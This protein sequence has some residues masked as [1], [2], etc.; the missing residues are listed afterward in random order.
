[1]KLRFILLFYILFP[2][3]MLGQI[4]LSGKVIDK[5]NE[6]VAFANVI[7]TE[8]GTDKVKG[9][10]TDKTGSFELKLSSALYEVEIS[11]VGYTSW[12]ETINLEN[13]DIHLGVIKLAESAT[14]LNEIVIQ[15]KRPVIENKIDRLVFNVGNSTIASGGTAIDII[16]VTPGVIAN[17]N[18]ISMIGRSGV[19]V[20]ING[21]LIQL[22]GEEL[23]SYLNT[24]SSNN[25]KSVEVITS[26]P[27]KYDAE[28]NAGLINIVLRK[29]KRNSWYNYA[30]SNYT[31][32]TYSG[33]ALGNTFLFNKNKFSLYASIDG[34]LG[35]KAQY[36]ESTI[37]Y[38]EGIWQGKTD[39]KKRLDNLSGRFTLGYNI[40]PKSSVGITYQGSI[41]DKDVHDRDKTKIFNSQ[42]IRV[43]EVISKGMNDR[44]GENHDLN[45]SYE[46]Q[47]DTLGKK[48]EAGLDYFQYK[49]D[50]SRVFTSE[51]IDYNPQNYGVISSNTQE[52]TNYNF[53][54]DILHPIGKT[55][56]SYGGKM[57]FTN[58]V[59]QLASE[60][61]LGRSDDLILQN[62]HF[63]YDENIQAIYADATS[64]INEK[65]TLKLGLRLE[66]TQTKGNSLTTSS[67]FSRDYLNL[68]PTIYFNHNPNKENSYN[69]SYSRRIR[70]PQ[71]SDLNPFR[72]YINAISYTEGNPFLQPQTSH[73]FE[74][75][76]SYKN[77]IISRIFSS[78]S[79]NGYGQIPS[80]DRENNQQIYIRKNFYNSTV[81][82]ASQIYLKDIFSWWKTITQATFYHFSSSYINN[83]SLSTDLNKG[84]NF[85]FYSNH[86][87]TLS[88]L[89]SAEFTFN[90]GAP[91]TMLL[92]KTSSSVSVDLGFR[93]KLFDEKLHLNFSAVD[94]L[95]TSART[96][97]AMTNGVPQEYYNYND[98]RY[99]RLGL[100]YK[101][102]NSKIKARTTKSGNR[103]EQNRAG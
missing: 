1:M 10:T 22:S 98:N 42:N 85:Q 25:I 81:I 53:N 57:T 19:G 18:A 28:G 40:T 34:T 102:G 67:E 52:V 23:L 44:E 43:G 78:I 88:K 62:D 66:A 55:M 31:Q 2:V 90:Y 13:K 100:E 95:K 7:V 71:F 59:N 77:S 84:F 9:K 47:L 61:L 12:N 83:I 6:P 32:R 50:Q 36:I 86:N 79:R 64:N 96:T 80:V 69:F 45:L 37:G 58:T 15:G 29:P 72:W 8:K 97:R 21:K 94:I 93:L 49:N 65:W 24:I 76:Y 101:F 68:F 46:H 11:F 103:D 82:G 70:R 33:Y 39:Y 4:N 92:F 35:N 27:A 74:F 99:F 20:M 60:N 16:K 73:N 3:I 14:S 48:L 51:R 17:G 56:F 26:P 75:K 63:D 54:L 30:R 38:D 87:F 41:S 89:A 91:Q 5:N